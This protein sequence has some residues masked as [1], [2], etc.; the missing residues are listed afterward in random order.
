MAEASAIA[1]PGLDGSNRLSVL[2]AEIR[3]AHQDV[4]AAAKTA[5]LRAIDAGQ[6]LLEAKDALQHGQWLPWLDN[7]GIPARTAQAYMK[8]AQL[9][10]AN[11]QRVAHLGLSQALRAISVA[12][13]VKPDPHRGSNGSRTR[14]RV[15]FAELFTASS[16]EERLLFLQML[17]DGDGG[18]DCPRWLQGRTDDDLRQMVMNTFRNDLADPGWLIRSAMCEV[19]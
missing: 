17:R 7:L 3:D 8:L 14:R 1:P 16:A 15:S 4:G 2:A 19:P 18:Q 13:P 9:D 11:A 12:G 6:R 5:V 10:P